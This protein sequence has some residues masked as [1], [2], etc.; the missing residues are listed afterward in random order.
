MPEVA[1]SKPAYRKVI[2][3]LDSVQEETPLPG[4]ETS[5][6]VVSAILSR[7]DTGSG[8]EFIFGSGN[9]P[10]DESDLLGRSVDFTNA[11]SQPPATEGFFYRVPVALA[12]GSVAVMIVTFYRPCRMEGAA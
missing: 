9:G 5:Q 1:G 4:V 3:P 7:C 10:L 11:G 6:K 8:V 12:P 2:I